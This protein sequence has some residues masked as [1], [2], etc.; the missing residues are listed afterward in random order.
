MLSEGASKVNFGAPSLFYLDNDYIIA[1][2]YKT[3]GVNYWFVPGF[4]SAQMP[5]LS[6]GDA[7]SVFSTIRIVRARLAKVCES[8]LCEKN[9]AVHFVSR[10]QLCVETSQWGACQSLA[11][12]GA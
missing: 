1:F 5:W 12:C 8:C 3:E 9:F 6:S 2:I 11:L 7:F 10:I 4:R